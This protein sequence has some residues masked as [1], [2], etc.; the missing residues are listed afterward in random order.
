MNPRYVIEIAENMSAH[1]CF[2]YIDTKDHVARFLFHHLK[3]DV[4]QDA[5]FSDEHDDAFRIVMCKVPREQREIFLRAIELLPGFMAYVG[6]KKYSA[7]CREFFRKAGE[8]YA[9][10]MGLG[11][12]S[13]VQ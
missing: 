4:E 8:F 12:A 6:R 1:D 3:I 9:G 5:E 11:A 7:Y 13:P 2:S 10:K